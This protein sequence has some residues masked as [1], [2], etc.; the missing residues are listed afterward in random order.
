MCSGICGLQAH[1]EQG[2]GSDEKPS[3]GTMWWSFREL[4]A[5]HLVV[6]AMD[7]AGTG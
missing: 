4:G 1:G 5:C 6:P 2:E 7:P 3:L